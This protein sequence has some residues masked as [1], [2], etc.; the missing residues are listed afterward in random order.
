MWFSRRRDPRIHDEIQFHRDHLID[1]HVAAGMS[2]TDAERRAFM[3]FGNVPL[4]EEQV[5]DARGRWFEDLG[6]D[7]RYALR[8]LGRSRGFTVVA[9]L[10]LALG[11]GANTAIFSV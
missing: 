1:E 9:V 2:R 8:T 11:I 6:M 5:K 7:I 4:I 10:T 3:E